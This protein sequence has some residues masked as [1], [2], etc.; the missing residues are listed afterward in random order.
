MSKVCEINY[1]VYKRK[2]K[3]AFRH[4]HYFFAFNMI[5]GMNQESKTAENFETPIGLK[6]K[7]KLNIL[8]VIKKKQGVVIG[9]IITIQMRLPFIRIIEKMS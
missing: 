2:S 9:V 3:P 5:H 8:T 1:L 6:R 4:W 7:Q